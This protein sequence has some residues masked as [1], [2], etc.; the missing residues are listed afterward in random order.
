METIVT[1]APGIL[2]DGSVWAFMGAGASIVLAGAGSV[3]GTYPAAAKG[4]GVIAENPS[5]F[6]KI[7]P[8]V[9]LPGSSVIYG[10]LI[11]LFIFLKL[12]NGDMSLTV[13]AQLFF[14]GLTMGLAGLFT[15]WLQG[16]AAA[17][18]VA[19]V[20]K[21]ESAFTPAI[22]L[23]ALLETAAIFALLVSI[24]LLNTIA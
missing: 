23:A 14:V 22:V 19:A 4:A 2:A 18:G 9:A 6:G 17:A 15:G 13:G 10:F 3:L 8:L 16:K 24:L 11:S 12:G 1:T 5:A 20:G 7:T 21:N